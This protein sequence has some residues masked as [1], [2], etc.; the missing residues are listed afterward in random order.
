MYSKK[1]DE[2][3]RR[4][5]GMKNGESDRKK[6]HYPH[7]I[8]MRFC[9]Q[10]SY[11]QALLYLKFDEKESYEGLSTQYGMPTYFLMRKVRCV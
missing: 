1:I 2:F 8:C 10:T 6:F 11:R 4:C 9:K 7:L 5:E 3:A